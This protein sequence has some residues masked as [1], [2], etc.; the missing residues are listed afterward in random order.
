MPK[1]K[2][3]G[4]DAPIKDQKMRDNDEESSSDDV[5][6]HSLSASVL[7]INKTGR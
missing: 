1:R 3:A 7:F 5:R 6:I 2:S 4:E